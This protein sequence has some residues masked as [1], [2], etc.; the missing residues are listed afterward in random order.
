MRIR[1]DVEDEDDSNN[2]WWVIMSDDNGEIW[3]WL[4]YYCKRKEELVIFLK[5]IEYMNINGIV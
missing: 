1:L 3:G 2:E 5:I 4:G